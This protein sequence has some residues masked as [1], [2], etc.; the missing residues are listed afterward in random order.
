MENLEKKLCSGAVTTVNT[1]PVTPLPAA[2]NVPVLSQ[3]REV[4]REYNVGDAPPEQRWLD[5]KAHVKK[6]S[7]GLGSNIEQG[8]FISYDDGSMT[9]GFPAGFA[10]DYVRERD[11]LERLAELARPFFGDNVK[12]KIEIIK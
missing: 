10:F 9:V 12:L 2:E 1:A 4:P 5:Y 6:Q 8:R 7:P 3:V 11:H